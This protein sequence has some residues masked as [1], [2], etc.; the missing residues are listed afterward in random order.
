M[1]NDSGAAPAPRLEY[2]SY[3]SLNTYLDC[4][5]SLE[6]GRIRRVKRRPGPWFP[7]GTAVHSTIERYLREQV[8]QEGEAA[9]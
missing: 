5:R 3:S 2:M 8:T 1:A 6:L 7:G 9:S 4:P